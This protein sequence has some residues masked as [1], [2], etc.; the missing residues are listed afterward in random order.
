MY[1][2]KCLSLSAQDIGGGGLGSIPQSVKSASCHQ[3]I[4]IAATFLRSCVAQE[5]SRGYG[6]HHLL[7]ASA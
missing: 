2:D 3:R 5:L 6:P 1:L 7:H 4:A